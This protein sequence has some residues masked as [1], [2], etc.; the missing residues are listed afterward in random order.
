MKPRSPVNINLG[1]AQS[2]EKPDIKGLIVR[3]DTL[4]SDDEA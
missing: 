1:Y 2:L 4:N 3:K